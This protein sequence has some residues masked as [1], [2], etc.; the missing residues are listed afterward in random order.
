V[1][2]MSDQPALWTPIFCVFC[3]PKS[4]VYGIK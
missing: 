3:A 1:K 4:K 2:W